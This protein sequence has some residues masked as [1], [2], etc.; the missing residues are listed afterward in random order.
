MITTN[1]AYGGPMRRAVSF[2]SAFSASMAEENL[3]KERLP[4]L[5]ALMHF[6]P[7]MYSIITA[8]RSAMER[9]A[10]ARRLSVLRNITPITSRAPTRG[11]SDT[12][13]S[14]TFT[15]SR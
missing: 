10:R 3:A 15:V 9:L 2:Q 13:A 7:L 12:S 14:G 5:K 1:A 8:L 11:K 6:M 4:M